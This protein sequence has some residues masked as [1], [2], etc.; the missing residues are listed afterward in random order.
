MSGREHGLQTL[1]S[2]VKEELPLHVNDRS[3]PLDFRGADLFYPRREFLRG[4]GDI[5][6]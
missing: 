2:E 1:S 4:F 6:R 3:T 5:A